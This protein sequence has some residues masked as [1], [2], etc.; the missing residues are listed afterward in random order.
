MRKIYSALNEGGTLVLRWAVGKDEVVNKNDRW[1]FLASKEFLLEFMHKNGFD[2]TYIQSKVEPIYGGNAECDYWY[3]VAKKQYSA[4]NESDRLSGQD[5]TNKDVGVSINDKLLGIIVSGGLLA[6]AILDYFFKVAGTVQA[7]MLPGWM[8]I[9]LAAGLAGS[10]VWGM[11]KVL[12]RNKN[13]TVSIPSNRIIKV[14][15]P[16]SDKA[17]YGPFFGLGNGKIFFRPLDW[18]FCYISNVFHDSYDKELDQNIET[19]VNIPNFLPITFRII[20]NNEEEDSKLW[21]SASPEVGTILS[22]EVALNMNEARLERKIT[23]EDKLGRQVD[24]TICYL[25]SLSQR[26]YAAINY[27]VKP[28]N[29]KGTIEF[30]SE[31]DANVSFEGHNQL[32]D[33]P[34]YIFRC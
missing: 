16:E 27:T 34:G 22:D 24:I 33:I 25:A 26:E 20:Q 12:R 15:D 13:R 31:I 1:V 6:A 29:F 14:E 5:K 23:W 19:I 4:F 28:R 10:L 21:F 7:L 9:I 32:Q 11:I 17:Y 3:V 2:V 30:I 18:N 8:L